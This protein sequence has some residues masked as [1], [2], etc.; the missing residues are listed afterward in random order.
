MYLFSVLAFQ[1]STYDVLKLLEV[2]K[3]VYICSVEKEEPANP[4]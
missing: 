2:L 4:T 3:H 1:S